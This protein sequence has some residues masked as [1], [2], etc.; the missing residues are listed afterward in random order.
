MVDGWVSFLIWS[1]FRGHSFIFGGVAITTK[2]QQKYWRPSP[3]T[4]PNFQGASDP[5]LPALGLPRG[6][7]ETTAA[8]GGHSLWF[9][10]SIGT[11]L[12]ERMLRVVW[13]GKTEYVFFPMVFP[14][15]AFD[16][17]HFVHTSCCALVGACWMLS[18]LLRGSRP[19]L[20]PVW[21]SIKHFLN[22]P[23]TCLPSQLARP[24][25]WNA[26]KIQLSMATRTWGLHDAPLDFLLNFDLTHTSGDPVERVSRQGQQKQATWPRRCLTETIK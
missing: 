23:R 15:W 8:G 5:V 2:D 20:K 9:A 4:T 17:T 19:P 26:L 14:S 22:F 25:Y 11:T 24:T 10:D 7:A 1:L 3:R 13:R 12:Q 16:L 21:Q 6:S 18:G